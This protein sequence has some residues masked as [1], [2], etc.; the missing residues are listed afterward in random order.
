MNKAHI[1]SDLWVVAKDS[2]AWGPFMQWADLG[3][4][5]AML[6]R[7][8]YATLTEEGEELLD[9]TWNM[10]LQVLD[11]PDRE[12]ASLEELLQAGVDNPPN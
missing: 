7:F 9:A 6:Q 10:L 2:P 3:I 11:A 4:P 12:Y 1:L 8:G 5:A